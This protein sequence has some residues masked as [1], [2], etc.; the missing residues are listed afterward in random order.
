[1]TQYAQSYTNPAL[2]NHIELNDLKSFELHSTFDPIPI[3]LV[4]EDYERMRFGNGGGD[5]DANEN[6]N[7]KPLE[8]NTLMSACNDPFNDQAPLNISELVVYNHLLLKHFGHVHPVDLPTIQGWGEEGTTSS[9]TPTSTQPPLLSFNKT[10]PSS[11]V[12]PLHSFNMLFD[13]AKVIATTKQIFQHH[14]HFDT[15]VPIYESTHRA[16]RQQQELMAQKQKEDD[17]KKM[18]QQQ[19][20]DGVETTAA[21]PPAPATTT[22]THHIPASKSTK[23]TGA[24]TYDLSKSTNEYLHALRT[25]QLHAIHDHGRHY[26]PEEIT[27][28]FHS[29]IL[30]HPDLVPFDKIREK[31]VENK[32]KRDGSGGAKGGSGGN[33][34]A[35]HKGKK[36]SKEV[37][38]FQRWAA[39]KGKI[40][41]G[42]N[43]EIKSMM[44]PNNTNNTKYSDEL[45]ID[46]PGPFASFIYDL[47][48]PMN[49][50]NKGGD[51]KDGGKGGK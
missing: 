37:T 46:P 1:M 14:P 26:S 33:T 36:P 44:T 3:D 17:E 49:Q 28:H 38:D 42:Q 27:A 30:P 10:D 40:A 21:T 22:P 24:F 50:K 18:K 41:T 8:E 5:N 7:K 19:Q 39:A 2:N 34:D 31:V 25:E 43:Y 13:P 9:T 4:N 15:E 48:R 23:A 6:K 20:E 51:G 47:M 16:L 32:N 29:R 12:I 35:N 45:N 11:Y